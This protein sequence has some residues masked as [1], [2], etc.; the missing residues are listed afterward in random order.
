MG[1][2]AHITVTANEPEVTWL[3]GEQQTSPVPNQLNT[4]QQHAY[5]IIVNHL[6]NQ[7]AGKNSDQQG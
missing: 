1:H 6:Q 3:Q 5:G 2:L 7:L 4:S